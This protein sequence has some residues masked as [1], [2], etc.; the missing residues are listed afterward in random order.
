MSATPSPVDQS[1][2]AMAVLFRALALGGLVIPFYAAQAPTIT[3]AAS[4]AGVAVVVASS[5]LL[6]GGLLGFIFGIPRTLQHEAPAP[7]E[8]AEAGK[9]AR[10]KPLETTYIANTNLEQISDWLTKILVG[11]GLTQLASLPDTLRAYAS[12][13]GAGLG[14]FASSQIFAIGILVF[15]VINGFLIAY[16]WTRLYLAGAMRQ[17]DSS[18]RLAAVETKLDAIDIDARALSMVQRFLNPTAGSPELSQQDLNAAISAATT[19]TKSQIFWHARD[20]RSENW[21]TIADKPKM[22]RTIPIFRALIASDTEHVYHANHGQ[23]GFALKDQRTPGWEEALTELTEAIRLRGDWQKSDW[24]QPTY[25]FVRAVCRINLDPAYTSGQPSDETT[26]RA[27][28]ADLE[29]AAQH[30]LTK[31]YFQDE[32]DIIKWMELNGVSKTKRAGHRTNDKPA[33][34]PDSSP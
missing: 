13:V 17:A 29:V 25:E 26:R 30:H 6:A 1:E 18:S 19:T 27:I 23:L 7:A 11:V 8:G 12:Y 15:F 31:S 5:A 14:G 10:D 34:V 9:P 28:L 33:P 16:L 3:Q 21:R 2:R 4:V 22:E 24:R 32:P 20:V